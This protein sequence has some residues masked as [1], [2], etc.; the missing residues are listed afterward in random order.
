M[1][2]YEWIISTEGYNRRMERKLEMM[3]LVGN[4]E[5]FKELIR[6]KQVVEIKDEKKAAEQFASD[7]KKMKARFGS[8]IKKHG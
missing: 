2:I 8:K 3:A 4:V 1:T 6:N 5:L 7:F